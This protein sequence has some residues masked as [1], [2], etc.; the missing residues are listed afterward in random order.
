[1]II[2]WNPASP[3]IDLLVARPKPAISYL[4]EWYRSTSAFYTK[5]PE[6]EASSG[7]S[8]KTIRHCMPFLDSLGAGYI[9]ESWQ[10]IYI[11][12]KDDETYEFSQP[13]NPHIFNIRKKSHVDMGPFFH[14]Q[15]FVFHQPWFPE[16]PKGW[17]MLYVQP[18]NRP[19]LPFHFLSGIVD[20]DRYSLG[21]AKNNTPFYLKKG[22]EGIIP[23]GTPL[24]QMIPIKRSDW[25]SSFSGFNEGK[26][27]SINFKINEKFWGGYKK[28]FWTRKSYN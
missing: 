26:Q 18:L 23:A 28:N 2:K 9:Q 22:F 13:T 6:I 7:R 25:S 24:I 14:S 8:N 27:K 15:E 4:P 16:L 3:D 10:D 17:S 11:N 20:S 21:E 12:F 5:K 19:D 1:M